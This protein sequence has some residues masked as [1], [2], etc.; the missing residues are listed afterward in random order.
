MNQRRWQP[1]DGSQDRRRRVVITGLGA[2]C[3]AGIG[4]PALWQALLE[5]RSGI[6]PIT[7]FDASDLKSRI[8]GEVKGFRS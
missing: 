3:A 7:L 4:V 2:V 6:S 8:A 5:G 1:T